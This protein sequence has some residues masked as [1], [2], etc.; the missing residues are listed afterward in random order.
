[1][2]RT[3]GQ[4]LRGLYNCRLPFREPSVPCATF[5]AG[6]QVAFAASASGSSAELANFAELENKVDSASQ[7][8]QQEVETIKKKLVTAREDRNAELCRPR[9]M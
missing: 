1:V 3:I 6:N 4:L 2:G 5:P 9:L 7:Q 8:A